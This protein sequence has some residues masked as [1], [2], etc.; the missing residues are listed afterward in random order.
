ME[1]WLQSGIKFN[2]VVAHN[3]EMAIGALLAIEDAGFWMKLS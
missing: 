3:D 2:A 1:N